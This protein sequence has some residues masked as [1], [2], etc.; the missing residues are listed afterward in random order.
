VR[1]SIVIFQVLQFLVIVFGS[2]FLKSC[3]FRAPSNINE[4]TQTF[5]INLLTALHCGQK[6][7]QLFLSELCQTSTKFYNFGTQIANTIIVL[8]KVY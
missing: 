2:P 5:K 7:T 4:L 1:F 6:M 3:K 8:C